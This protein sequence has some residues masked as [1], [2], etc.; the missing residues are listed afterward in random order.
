M[1]TALDQIAASF[2]NGF[3]DAFLQRLVLDYVGRQATLTLDLWV[4]DLSATAEAAREAHQTVTI[5]ILG[6]LWCIVEAPEGDERRA[7]GLWIDAGPV[8]SLE[9]RPPLPHVPDNA[10]AWWFF[11]RDWNAFIYIAAT[12]AAVART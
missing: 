5:N 9:E 10:F 2:P 8:T 12:D 11:V 6:L 3:H 4:G 7:E 1:Q